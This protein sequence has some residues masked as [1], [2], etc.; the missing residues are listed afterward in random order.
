MSRPIKFRIWDTKNK[1]WLAESD[2]NSLTYYGFHLFG[3]VMQMQQVYPEDVPNFVIEQYTGIEDKNGTEIYDGDL[4]HAKGSKTIFRV[5]WQDGG[6]GVVP[7][8]THNPDVAT[9]PKLMSFQLIMKHGG[10]GNLEV[11]GN[12][13]QNPELLED[14]Q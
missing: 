12:I 1:E 9:N 6:F 3:E 10:L 13:H 7:F 4:T 8:H 5:I 2:P 14:K 11:I